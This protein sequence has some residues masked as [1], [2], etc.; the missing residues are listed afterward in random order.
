M[1][2]C[3]WFCAELCAILSSSAILILDFADVSIGAVLLYYAVLPPSWTQGDQWL[4]FPANIAVAAYGGLLVILAGTSCLSVGF[5]MVKTLRA[6]SF[7]ACLGLVFEW[8]VAV[9]GLTAGKFTRHLGLDVSNGW[10]LILLAASA[11]HALRAGA[12][13]QLGRARAAFANLREGRRNEEESQRREQLSER[14]L[15]RRAEREELRAQMTAKYF[16]KP[17]E[18]EKPKKRPSWPWSSAKKEAPAE[19]EEKEAE[20]PS[21]LITKESRDDDTPAWARGRD[22]TVL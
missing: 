5:R 12:S 17:E 13:G 21:F 4:S 10:L 20:L 9:M 22:F 8:T 6:V 3:Q 11:R 14:L 15:E 1:G 19:E 2:C 7:L 16:S 18:E